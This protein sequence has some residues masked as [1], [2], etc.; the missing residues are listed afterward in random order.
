MTPNIALV[1]EHGTP[2]SLSQNAAHHGKDMKHH[3][4]NPISDILVGHF[5]GHL[6]QSKEEKGGHIDG[7]HPDSKSRPP[8][9]Q[10][11][12][13]TCSNRGRRSDAQ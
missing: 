3:F 10:Q 1:M 12:N 9:P 13:E 5:G 7:S 2:L 11:E 4:G 8:S 6:V